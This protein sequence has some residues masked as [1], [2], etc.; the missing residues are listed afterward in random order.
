MCVFYDLCHCVGPQVHLCQRDDFTGHIQQCPGCHVVISSRQLH[1]REKFTRDVVHEL[2]HAAGLH[3][4]HQ[5]FDRGEDCTTNRTPIIDR[6]PDIT[7]PS[8]MLSAQFLLRARH[9]KDVCAKLPIF[10][11]A[12]V[13]CYYD[14]TYHPVTKKRVT[15]WSY[16]SPAGPVELSAD[17][18]ELNE[19]GLPLSSDRTTLQLLYAPGTVPAPVVPAAAA[20]E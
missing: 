3:H 18:V 13:M 14:S 7:P 5:R 1:S 12:S 17:Q 16:A 10:S 15:L 19:S 8:W 2:L 9:E 6:T 4:E 11:T 20:V